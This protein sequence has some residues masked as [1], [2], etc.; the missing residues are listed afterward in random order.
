VHA[1][2]QTAKPLSWNAGDI[3]KVEGV[4]DVVKL[5]HGIAIVAVSFEQALAAR[6]QLSVTW[7]AAPSADG[8][9]SSRA[10]D[11]DYA[12]LA[13]AEAHGDN[14][15]QSYGDADA[16]FE[17]AR[18]VYRAEF[19]SDYAYHAQMEP[20]NAVVRF[21]E[22]LDHVEVW[23]GTQ[24]PGRARSSI[25][26]ALGFREHQV[27]HHAMYLGGGFGRRSISDYTIEAAL[28]A[29]AVRRP[30]KMIWTREED[31]GF[32]M[33]RP[34]A[35]Q[36]V[37]AALDEDGQV[38][39]WRHCVVGDG[40]RL[41]YS[42]INLGAYYGIA[43]VSVERRGTSHGI[44]LKHWRAVAHPFNLFAIECL[45][46]EMAA[47]ED[48]DS[49]AFRR[50]RLNPTDRALAVFERVEAMS[51]WFRA[52]DGRALGFAVSERSGSVAAGVVEI[53]LDRSSGRIRVHRVWMAVDAGTIVQPDMA[54]ANVESG[55]V[56]GISS[57][58]KERATVKD[59]AVMQ[60]NFHD[61]QLLRMSESPEAIHVDFIDTDAAPAGIG[62]I[63]NPFV[64]AA[65]ANAFY[66]LT[67]KRL[68]HMPFTPERVRQALSA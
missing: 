19:R 64:A 34:Q 45:V 57:V 58:L 56:Y 27:T 29:R 67:G 35:L 14:V 54:R 43:N 39:G 18:K 3:R 24:S 47:A 21:N 2:V 4:V 1:P 62:E 7:S 30:V 65:V 66:A 51:D 63:G 25:A 8:F 59:G 48:M 11:E 23:E 61:Y 10:L 28:I 13:N 16:A 41:L 38:N 5:D 52:R 53:S 49:I 44:R 22:A 68:R 26:G 60:S 37:E 42:G 12:E 31:I 9:D 15:V 6:K 33:F 46:D 36:R 55:I 40:D 20:L 17:K 32:G 50:A